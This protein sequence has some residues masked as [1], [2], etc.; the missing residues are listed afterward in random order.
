MEVNREKMEALAML[1][2][3]ILR[4]ADAMA[5]RDVRPAEKKDEVIHLSRRIP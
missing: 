5:E 3:E 2:G 1:V 4:E